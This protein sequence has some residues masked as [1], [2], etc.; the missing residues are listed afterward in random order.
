MF[1]FV[2][3]V[4]DKSY[5]LIIVVAATHDTWYQ[6]DAGGLK[7][8]RRWLSEATPSDYEMGVKAAD[9]PAGAQDFMPRCLPGCDASGIVAIKKC[10]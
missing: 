3:C 4:N 2:P 5:L 7:T 1:K 8:S 9:T 10:Y 6:N